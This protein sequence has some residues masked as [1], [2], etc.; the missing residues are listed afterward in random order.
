[1]KPELGFFPAWAIGL[2]DLEYRR[3][4]ELQLR[5]REARIEGQIPDTLLLVEHDPVITLGRAAQEA[6]V[7]VS[8]LE[9][10]KL[11]VDLVR[12]ERG[13]DVTY[14]GPGQITGYP[15]LDLGRRERDLYA[16]LRGLEE[17]MLRTLAEYGLAGERIEGLTGIWVKGAKIGAIGVKVSRWV[18]MHGFAFNV[19]PDLSHFE[20][21][22]PCGLVGKPVTSLRRLLGFRTP[23][24]VEVAHRLREH[25]AE[26][27]SLECESLSL[28]ALEQRLCCGNRG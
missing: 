24:P 5:L 14:H 13:G 22:I 28:E 2:I 12:T 23:D 9:L 18:T 1:V 11:G 15:I 3:S 25:L 20:R 4:W 21:I 10:G 26:V 17:V 16:Y 7:L 6:N 27:F 19:D 8:E